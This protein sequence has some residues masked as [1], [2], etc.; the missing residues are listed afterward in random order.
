MPDEL[1][2][3]TTSSDRRSVGNEIGS[4]VSDS[5]NDVDL[6]QTEETEHEASNSGRLVVV[7]LVQHT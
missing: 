3:G 5:R 2:P 6:G 1:G 7:G 4:G